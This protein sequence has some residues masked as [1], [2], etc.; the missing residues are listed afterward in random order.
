MNHGDIWTVA[1]GVYTSQPR[2]ALII[3]DDRYDATDSV[4]VL[5][6]TS[7]VLDAPSLRVPFSASELSGLVRDSQIMIDK[8]ATVR[9]DDV[10]DRV[11]CLTAAQLVGVERVLFVFL[12]LAG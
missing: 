10:Q 9:R 1:G 12:G 3:Q 6:V 7:T 4:T 11:G 5:P 8:L 2:L